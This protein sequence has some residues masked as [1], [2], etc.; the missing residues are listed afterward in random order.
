MLFNTF[1]DDEIGK[2]AIKNT[3]IRLQTEI[4]ELEYRQQVA[5]SSSGTLEIFLKHNLT[6]KESISKGIKYI[7]LTTEEKRQ[8][9]DFMIDK[10]YLT[11]DINTFEIAWKI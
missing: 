4:D 10:I 8:I 3:V 2:K 5:L 1:G 7:D 9:I 11:N 6:L